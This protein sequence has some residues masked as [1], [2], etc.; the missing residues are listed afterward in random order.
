MVDI[1]ISLLVFDSLKLIGMLLSF[2]VLFIIIPRICFI[3]VKRVL[4]FDSQASMKLLVSNIIGIYTLLTLLL[5]FVF[6]FLFFN[7]LTLLTSNAE[8]HL[9]ITNVKIILAAFLVSFGFI[10]I[11]RISTLLKKTELIK[12]VFDGKLITR[13]SQHSANFDYVSFKNE[14][15]SFLFSIFVTALLSLLMYVIYNLFYKPL[16]SFIV[17]NF[18]ITNST[19]LKGLGYSVL[20]LGLLWSFSYAGEWLLHT[21]GA[22]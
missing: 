5:G 1:D 14:L 19:G 4:S 22:H 11:L 7:K 21:Y 20:L 3:Y 12:K 8:P 15:S 10:W 18:T 9:E 17:I 13:L 6:N 2:A 16:S